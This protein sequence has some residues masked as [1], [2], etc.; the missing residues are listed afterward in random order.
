M[1]NSEIQSEHKQYEEV[2][3]N[4]KPDIDF[5]KKYKLE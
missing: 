2:E 5:H 4:P 1:K 3:S